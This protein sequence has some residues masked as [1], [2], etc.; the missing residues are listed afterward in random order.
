MLRLNRP[1][2]ALV[3]VA[4]LIALH[5]IYHTPQ[6][7]ASAIASKLGGKATQR[8]NKTVDAPLVKS[9]SKSKS[10]GRKGLKAKEAISEDGLVIDVKGLTSYVEGKSEKHPI[11]L[12][13]ERGRRLAKLVE[14]KEREIE[15]VTDSADDYEKVFKVKPPKGF[16]TW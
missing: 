3:A 7:H 10:K 15:S 2:L 12:L 4:A 5:F 14:S 16:D 9:K 13:I 1:V 8:Q 11:E 6:D